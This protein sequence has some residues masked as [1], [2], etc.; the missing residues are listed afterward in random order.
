MVLEGK[1][2]FEERT[3]LLRVV[4]VGADSVEALQ[5]HLLRNLRVVGDQRLVIGRAGDQRVPEALRVAKGEPSVRITLGLEALVSEPALPEADRLRRRDA[6]AD[7]V[8][9]P[10]ARAAGTG[11]RVLEEGDVRAGIAVLV[12]V[13]QVVDGGV[14][15]VD[16]LLDEP[17][18]E[19]PRVEVDVAWRIP[20]DRRDVVDPLELHA[21]RL[22][23]AGRAP[24]RVEH[25]GEPADPLRPAA[26]GRDGNEPGQMPLGAEREPA[27]ERDP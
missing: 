1:G 2:S 6:P 27:R 9:H 7:R 10:G 21:V 3:A 22:P 12:P 4:R 23:D 19:H 17:Q 15:L 14:V 8:H 11:V 24:R 16:A 5:R 20:R 26:S 25:P 18:P 13:E